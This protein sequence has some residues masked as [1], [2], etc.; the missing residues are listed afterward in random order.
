MNGG[1]MFVQVP[2]LNI[3]SNNCTLPGKYLGTK[4]RC[5][6]DVNERT[7]GNVLRAAWGPAFDMLHT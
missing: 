5:M 6:S 1:R 7:C 3:L 2:A 4:C